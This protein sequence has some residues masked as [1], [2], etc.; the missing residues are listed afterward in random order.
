MVILYVNLFEILS[1]KMNLFSLIKSPISIAMMILLIFVWLKNK[2]ANFVEL[3]CKKQ[4]CNFINMLLLLCFMVGLIIFIVAQIFL[5]QLEFLQIKYKL[6]AIGSVLVDLFHDMTM[7][8]QRA[9]ILFYSINIIFTAKVSLDLLIN[10]LSGY[11]IW[12][13]YLVSLVF[14]LISMVGCY[15]WPIIDWLY[16]VTTTNIVQYLVFILITAIYMIN[17]QNI[18]HIFCFFG[19]QQKLDNI[20]GNPQSIKI[21]LSTVINKIIEIYFMYLFG[22]YMFSWVAVNDILLLA[23]FFMLTMVLLLNIKMLHS[24]YY[25]S[26]FQL[27]SVRELKS[28]P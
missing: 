3:L 11:K 7:N 28:I 1:N 27:S 6:P 14:P 17:Y 5:Q 23:A 15:Y 21:K 10:D 24:K 16:A 19:K 13:I 22:Y 9:K 20:D 2:L 8:Q 25:A 18:H 12:M 26:F 4:V